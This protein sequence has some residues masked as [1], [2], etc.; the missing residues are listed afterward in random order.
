MR[1]RLSV[2]AKILEKKSLEKNLYLRNRLTYGCQI[3][4]RSKVTSGQGQ[5]SRSKVKVT[6][7]VKEKAGGL[8]PTSSSF[9]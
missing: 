2:C 6:I 1:R 3:L 7:N 4:S 5:R 9:I 8:T